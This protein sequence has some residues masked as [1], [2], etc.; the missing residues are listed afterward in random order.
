MQHERTN[1]IRILGLIVANTLTLVRFLLAFLFPFSPASWHLP[2]I[3]VALSS[4]FLDGQV[5]RLCKAES[6]FGRLADPIADK[7]FC[8][9][10]FLTLVFQGRLE[11]WAFFLLHSR[12]LLI[13]YAMIVGMLTHKWQRIQK[14]KPR[15]TGKI[16]T[17]AQLLLLLNFFLVVVPGSTL[18]HLSIV[19]SIVAAIDYWQVYYRGLV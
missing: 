1:A 8:L 17:A 2:M 19:A 9:S 11:V 13:I 6:T 18:L 5:A 15:W 4:E 10:A 7:A 12:D 16:A 3:V 14:L